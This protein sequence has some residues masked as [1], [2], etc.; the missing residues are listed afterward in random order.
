M[1]RNLKTI[2]TTAL[3]GAAI[4][5]GGC[6]PSSGGPEGVHSYAWYKKNPSAA[7]KENEWCKKTQEHPANPLKW[8]ASSVGRSC[9]NAASVVDDLKK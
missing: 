9:S 1:D 2:V 6:S 3:M 5:I 7:R 8:L 4:F